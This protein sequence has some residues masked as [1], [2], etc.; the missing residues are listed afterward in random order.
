[1][2]KKILELASNP[3]RANFSLQLPRPGFGPAAELPALPRARRRHAG[4]SSRFAGQRT[5]AATGAPRRLRH[6]EPAAQLS[7][8][9]LAR[10][11][12]DRT[13]R[14]QE[15]RRSSNRRRS[16]VAEDRV[17]R[18]ASDGHLRYAGSR[19]RVSLAPNAWFLPDNRIWATMG[20]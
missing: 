6:A 16:T 19:R 10:P 11:E 5:C 9:T 15:S 2:M 14:V 17:R 13:L 1:M 8:R 20:G 18:V 3:Q 4:C 12:N 7:E